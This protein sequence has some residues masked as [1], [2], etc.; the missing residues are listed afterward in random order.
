LKPLNTPDKRPLGDR[1]L[2]RIHRFDLR[3]IMRFYFFLG[4]I[5][6]VVIIC[7][8]IAGCAQ[9]PA[10]SSSVDAET[11]SRA[12]LFEQKSRPIQI[13]PET[14]V[15]DARSLFDFKTHTLAGA[16]HV[17]FDEFVLQRWHRGNEEKIT[18]QMARRLALLGISPMIHV[19]VI[20]RGSSGHGEE[21]EV[22]LALMALGVE[23]VQL[24]NL[25]DLKKFRRRGEA[26]RHA[27]QRVWSPRNISGFFCTPGI[28]KRDAVIINVDKKPPSLHRGY[29]TV[30]VLKKDWHGF[31]NQKDFSPDPK[32]KTDLAK[33]D[34]NEKTELMVSGPS[35]AIVTFSLLQSGFSR[36]CLLPN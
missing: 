13:T 33:N 7:G 20:G 31:V 3:W 10:R 19:V 14:V 5:V 2:D 25:D 26:P 11:L 30:P 35:A 24:A 21:G 1:V 27:N 29:S 15:L 18:Q 16:V 17:D 22:A 36:S 6:V 28:D 34:L 8:L 9:I 23:R 4:I 32:I 12:Y